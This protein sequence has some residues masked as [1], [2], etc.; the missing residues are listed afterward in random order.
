MKTTNPDTTSRIG[1]T[2]CDTALERLKLLHETYGI[3]WRK[4]ANLPEFQGI[5]P[6][7]LSSFYKGTWLPKN[8]EARRRLGLSLPTSNVV[9]VFGSVPD[10]S[11]ALTANKCVCGQWYIS[12]HPLRRNCFV[13]SPYRGKKN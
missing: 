1:V 9:V 13:C 2:S 7:S 6:G 12:N 11:Q 5:K 3:S 4:I 10:G 8:A